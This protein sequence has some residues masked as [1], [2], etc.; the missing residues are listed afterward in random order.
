M[1]IMISFYVFVNFLVSSHTISAHGLP[2][3]NTTFGKMTFG[4][5]SNTTIENIITES[6]TISR[7]RAEDFPSS[8]IS[9]TTSTSITNLSTL[10]N[11]KSYFQSTSTY[12]STTL[13]NPFGATT[14]TFL[15]STIPNNLYNISDNSNKSTPTTTVKPKYVYQTFKPVQLDSSKLKQG[16]HVLN[17]K[18]N[19]NEGEVFV[20][21]FGMCAEE[22]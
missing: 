8:L 10:E 11:K 3:V 12:R 4:F 13:S 22:Y 1:K 14:Q 9:T 19:C 5:E 7:K 20:R 21:E 15:N 16:K 2:I 18:V 17:V 6:T